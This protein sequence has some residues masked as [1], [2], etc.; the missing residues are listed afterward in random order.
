MFILFFLLFIVVCDVNVSFG[1]EN[2]GDLLEWDLS[3]F[4]IFFDVLEFV[5]DLV[6]FEKECFVFVFDYEGKLVDLDVV[7]M[8]ICIEC[9]EKIS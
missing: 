7:E 4:Y 5:M 1:S 8:F 6:F 2:F 3:D 9:N